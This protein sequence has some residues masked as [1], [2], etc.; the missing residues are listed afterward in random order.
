[1]AEGASLGLEACFDGDHVA[2]GRRGEG[3]VVREL[4]DSWRW[5]GGGVMAVFVY[6]QK[7]GIDI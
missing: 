4:A 1:M 7:G 5:A 3:Y 2:N 6:R